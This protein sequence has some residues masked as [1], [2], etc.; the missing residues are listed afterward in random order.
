MP[1][2]KEMLLEHL[3]YTFEKEGWQPPL[4][5]AVAG[6]TAAQA[7]WKPDPERHSIWQ[8]VRHVLLWKRGV[9]RAW[10][11][12]PP[13]FEQI[14]ASDW[15]D[16]SGDQAAWDADVAA[17]HEIYREFRAKLEAADEESLA[18]ALRSYQQSQ[19]P[20]VIAHRLMQVFTH[21]EYHA[22]QVQYLRALQRIPAD[23]WFN[24]AWEGDVPR[25]ATLL[26]THPELLNA[27]SRDGWTALQLAA[28]LG[29]VE[30]TRFL[31]ERGADI[32]ALSKNEMANTALHGGIAGRRAETTALLLDAGADAE[33]SDAWG[34]TALHLA[35]H[36][37]VPALV[38]LLL[39]RGAQVNARRRDGKTPLGVALAEGKTEAADLL[40]RHGGV[41]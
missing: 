41:E 4:A 9:L 33:A 31:L 26:N 11:G 12:D 21:D 37:G 3:T 6:L 7:A 36:E 24:A 19:Q 15:K 38:E 13:D 23:R 28:Y 8:I 34:A 25:L 16:V 39:A 35:A 22:G 2:A 18:L 14:V 29:R 1:T 27:H 40:G 10:A 30:A 5:H 17:L 32:A 20:V